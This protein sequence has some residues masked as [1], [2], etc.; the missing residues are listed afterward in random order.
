[1]RLVSL[2]SN[3][4]VIA[5]ILG[6]S[7]NLPKPLVCKS[8]RM[9]FVT[10]TIIFVVMKLAGCNHSSKSVSN[11]HGLETCKGTIFSHGLAIILLI[12]VLINFP[13]Q[14]FQVTFLFTLLNKNHRDSVITT[15]YANDMCVDTIKCMHTED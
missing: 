8:H 5:H 6:I 10:V 2:L 1:M 12:T 13:T 15:S 9:Q 4:H 3:L 7:L 11:F 14:D